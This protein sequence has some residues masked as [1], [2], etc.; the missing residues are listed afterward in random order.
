MGIGHWALGIGQWLLVIETD[1]YSGFQVYEV[2]PTN[3]V[4]SGFL[5]RNR[6]YSRNPLSLY[7]TY[8]ESA[9][10]TKNQQITNN[11]VS[12]CI[13]IVQTVNS[14]QSTVNSQQFRRNAT[15]IDITN[16]PIC[17]RNFPV[18]NS[19]SKAARTFSHSA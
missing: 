13:G 6:F 12:G 9:V 15:G 16:Y 17:D 19:V 4:S 10:T 11:I 18:S 1:N 7:F 8:L 2:H 14:Q 5:A 3:P